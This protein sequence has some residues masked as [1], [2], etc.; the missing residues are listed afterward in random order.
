[1]YLPETIILEVEIGL[2]KKS[3]PVV[4]ELSYL[5]DPGERGNY[6]LPPSGD[7]VQIIG[8]VLEKSEREIPLHYLV[9][10]TEVEEDILEQLT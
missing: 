1:M 6:Y 7:R 2:G 4:A 9:N 3:F 10:Q 8:A 5:H